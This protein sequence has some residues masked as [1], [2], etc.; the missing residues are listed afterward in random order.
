LDAAL[1]AR[2]VAAAEAGL[3]GCRPAV[4]CPEGQCEV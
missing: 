4:S 3:I 2:E 1:G